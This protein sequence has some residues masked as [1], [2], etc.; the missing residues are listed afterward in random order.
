MRDLPTGTVTFLFTDIEGSTRLLERLGDRY[1]GL[2]ADYRRLIRSIFAGRGGQEVDTQGDA[3]FFAFPRAK[4]AVIA[5]VGAQRALA[6]H[7]WPDGAIVHVRMGLHTGE[8][9]SAETGYV[10]MDVH[11]AARICAA[12]SGGQILVSQT[13]RDLIYDSLPDQFALRDLGEHRLKDITHPLHLYQV[14]APGLRA[15]FRP[16]RSLTSLP[17]QLTSFVGRGRELAEVRHLLATDRLVTLTGVGGAGKTRLAIQVAS[18]AVEDFTDGVWLV[19]LAALSDPSLVPQTVAA[20]LDVREQPG[21]PILVSLVDSLR[22]KQL[23]FVLDNCEHL[24]EACA[25]IVGDVLRACPQV[26]ILATSREALGIEGEVTCQVPPLSIPD[27]AEFPPIERLKKY[28]AVRL[29]VDRA[30][31]V[32]P[33]F[34]VTAHNARTV[35]QL[36]SRLDGM[37]LA[38]ELAAARLKVLSV[39]QILAR[40]DDRF[41]LLIEGRRGKLP[42]QQTLRATM[43]WSYQLLSAAEQTLLRHLSAFAGWFDL[44]SVEHVCAARPLEPTAVLDLLA[45]LVDKS[46][47]LVEHRNG[48][49]RYRMLDTIRDYAAE[50]LREA[51]EEAGLRGRHRD[52]FLAAAERADAEIRGPRQKLWLDR[53]QANHDNF[54]T[55]LEWSS[56]QA[57]DDAGL[58]LAGALGWF[59]YDRGY[60]T[61]GRGWLQRLL[62]GTTSGSLSARAKALNRAGLLASFQGDNAQAIVL[63]EEGL[64]LARAGGDI[65]E[66]AFSLMILGWITNQPIGD[67]P[68]AR[69]LFEEALTLYRQYG[70]PWG[71]ATALHHLGRVLWRQGNYERAAALL[72][73]SRDRYRSYGDRLGMAWALH[74]LGL[75]ARS[76]GDLAASAAYH[77]ESLSLFR[78]LEQKAHYALALNSLGVLARQQ[79]DYDHAVALSEESLDLFREL[80]DKAGVG[81]ALYSLGMAVMRQGERDQADS[82]LRESLSLRHEL[83]DRRAIAEGLEAM[84][85]VAVAQGRYERAAQLFGAAE[86]LREQLGAPVP[87]SD[88]AEYEESVNTVRARLGEARLVQAW[89]AGRAMPPDRATAHALAGTEQ[90]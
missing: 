25:A 11:R 89:E 84:A 18:G 78:E 40:L 90:I 58:R 38:I 30:A 60:A 56:A 9:L 29:F 14:I 64:R 52:W 21:R 85:S 24:I 70:D 33:A 66:T 20:V 81:L 86:S 67:Y 32:A 50:K 47:V 80:G 57:G 76:R 63:S 28:E 45:Q 46:L 51:G 37:P 13:T 43:D 22:P 4:D 34:T 41:S 87:P 62:A 3:S 49:P 10:G 7:H 42:R 59:W 82:L 54:R 72:E 12:A 23:L 53:L 15:D 75:V 55:A 26:R 69:A 6:G 88:R 39:E 74:G 8:P 27:L 35:A 5:A 73:E 77:T 71:T 31:A 2:L 79:G 19:E 83:G 36:C 44:E 65:L 68:R 61:E 17:L 48:E 16:P 1:T